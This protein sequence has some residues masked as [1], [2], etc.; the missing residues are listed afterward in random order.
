MRSGI[1][2]PGN[3]VGGATG[4]ECEDVADEAIL[5]QRGYAINPHLLH[6]L[7]L[8][9]NGYGQPC[10]ANVGFHLKFE[11]DPPTAL[12][13]SQQRQSDALNFAVRP[14]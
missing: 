8:E 11:V 5:K 1:G 13:K 2:P 9:P 6:R 10:V 3:G 14:N 4:P 12:F 7:L